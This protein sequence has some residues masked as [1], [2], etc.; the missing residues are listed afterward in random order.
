MGSSKKRRVSILFT[1]VAG[2]SLL[3]GSSY[4]VYA[5]CGYNSGKGKTPAALLR[6]FLVEMLKYRAAGE[7]GLAV[8][9]AQFK[10]QGATEHFV[11]VCNQEEQK[12]HFL[13]EYC[14]AGASLEPTCTTECGKG[15][16]GSAGDFGVYRFEEVGNLGLCYTVC[17]FNCEVT[18]SV[19]PPV[20][21]RYLFETPEC[22]D[23][24]KLC[25]KL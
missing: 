17:K 4:G 5:V 15:V 18:R 14:P 25:N 8:F 11:K 22:D 2:A 21:L 12:T 13:S 3:L 24:D 1:M 16:Y 9:K 20:N 19:L 10:K 6:Y 7:G 23:K